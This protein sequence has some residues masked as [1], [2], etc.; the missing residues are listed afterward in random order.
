[1][2]LYILDVCVKIVMILRFSHISPSD[3]LFWGM[4][5]PSNKSNLSVFAACVC[6]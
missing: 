5:S 4:F 3:F 2:R 6:K 1:M